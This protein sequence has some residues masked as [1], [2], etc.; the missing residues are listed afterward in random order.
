MKDVNNMQI[1]LRFQIE[2]VDFA[3]EFF[4]KCCS[5][6]DCPFNVCPGFVWFELLISS[7]TPFAFGPK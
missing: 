7:Y 1:K 2:P 6:I 4:K 3:F 5:F